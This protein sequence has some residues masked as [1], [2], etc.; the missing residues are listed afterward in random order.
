[1]KFHAGWG[2][3]WRTV[4]TP[5]TVDRRF[6]GPR[7][8]KQLLSNELWRIIYFSVGRRSK[9]RFRWI[10]CENER[11]I[12]RPDELAVYDDRRW[13]YVDDMFSSIVLFT[14]FVLIS[15]AHKRPVS[16]G[17]DG[18]GSKSSRSCRKHKSNAQ[19]R[20]RE[21]KRLECVCVSRRWSLSLHVA[22]YS[23]WIGTGSCRV[24][25][26]AA[27]ADTDDGE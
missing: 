11:T 16:I 24:Q 25:H 4:S 26:V 15:S 27:R 1:M 21:T 9:T 8:A 5:V 17:R 18:A 20:T 3:V 22:P 12:E 13:I 19:T 2:R 7:T 6:R 23:L 10:V 14:R